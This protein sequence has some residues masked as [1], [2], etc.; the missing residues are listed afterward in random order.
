MGLDL[1]GLPGSGP[2]AIYRNN[3]MPAPRWL[4][5]MDSKSRALSSIA[6]GLLVVAFVIGAHYDGDGNSWTASLL[7]SVLY[8]VKRV[9]HAGSIAETPD[10][11]TTPSYDEVQD[12]IV[13]LD[14]DPASK[15]IREEFAADPYVM[16]RW[17]ELQA[18]HDTAA[19][20]GALQG[21]QEFGEKLAQLRSDPEFEGFRQRALRHPV[22]QALSRRFPVVFAARSTLEAAGAGA[23]SQGGVAPSGTH[24]GSYAAGDRQGSGPS[25][26]IETGGNE[27]TDTPVVSPDLGGGS[28]DLAYKGPPPAAP[29]KVPDAGSGVPVSQNASCGASTV[30]CAFGLVAFCGADKQWSC[31]KA[32]NCGAHEILCASGTQPVCGADGAWTCQSTGPQ[33]ACALDCPAGAHAV[34]TDKATCSG[35]CQPG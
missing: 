1:K 3:F 4:K 21:H 14:S 2:G 5:R 12:F 29:I 19:F 24:S 17:K 10:G 31:V 35:S 15:R 16:S 32:P 30:A 8:S 34:Y 20:V 18:N 22:G 6:C 33:N 11:W 9:F 7:Q 23:A 26:R 13:Y 27:A 25:N 28:G